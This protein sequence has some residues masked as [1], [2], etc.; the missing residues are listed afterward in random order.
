MPLD[1][2]RLG[3]IA[4]DATYEA[5]LARFE[6]DTIHSVNEKMHG[7]DASRVH[8]VLVSNLEGR[9]PGIDFDH[10]NLKQIAQAIAQNTLTTSAMVTGAATYPP[11]AHPA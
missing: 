10:L 6:R 9:F 1:A 8:A 3:D 4:H 11:H 5:V 2:R 7:Q